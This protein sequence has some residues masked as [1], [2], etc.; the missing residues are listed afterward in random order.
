MATQ[1]EHSH[2]YTTNILFITIHSY[3]FSCVSKLKKKKKSLKK[4]KSKQKSSSLPQLCDVSKQHLLICLTLWE[5]GETAP[6]TG[7]RYVSNAAAVY[8]H[9]STQICLW[10]SHFT[11]SKKVYPCRVPLLSTHICWKASFSLL[12]CLLRISTS[13]RVKSSLS[14]TSIRR[15]FV[16]AW[17]S[18]SCWNIFINFACWLLLGVRS[19]P[20]LLQ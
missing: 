14:V 13:P 1:A 5:S 12:S 8:S 3:I 7:S 6:Q 10:V 20:L 11:T 17:L 18:C 4:K 15:N 19:T 9:L 2:V 16:S